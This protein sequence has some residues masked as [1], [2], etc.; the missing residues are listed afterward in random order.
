M[1]A[2]DRTTTGWYNAIPVPSR[3]ASFRIRFHYRPLPPVERGGEC[4]NSTMVVVIDRHP[5]TVVRT[6]RPW[7]IVT[8]RIASVDALSVVILAVVSHPVIVVL[9]QR[10]AQQARQVNDVPYPPRLF[11]HLAPY[12]DPQVRRDRPSSSALIPSP[13]PPVVAV[14][15]TVAI[16]VGA[17][18]YDQDGVVFLPCRLDTATLME[19]LSGAE[20]SSVEPQ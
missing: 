5:A 18:A 15:V 3:T 4:R 9:P 12:Q 11:L 13:Y 7:F 2:Q 8:R 14:A 1:A 17:F 6:R 10:E 20:R 16:A 19:Q